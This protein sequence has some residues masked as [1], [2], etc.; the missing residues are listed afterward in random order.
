MVFADKLKDAERGAP[1]IGYCLSCR[2]E[3]G[4]NGRQDKWDRIVARRQRPSRRDE[5]QNW[6]VKNS[7][8]Q[9]KSYSHLQRRCPHLLKLTRREPQQGPGS[10]FRRRWD[11][12]MFT[13]NNNLGTRDAHLEIM[14]H[15]LR[16][17]NPIVLS[18]W[19]A[20]FSRWVGFPIG[21]KL[22]HL[23]SMHT[24]S[25]IDSGLAIELEYGSGHN[26]WLLFVLV[27]FRP[28]T[29]CHRRTSIT[30]SL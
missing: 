6:D 30:H 14:I 27:A 23:I 5:A 3:I 22:L 28:K 18:D 17:N 20:L 11:G 25:S 15:A 16:L 10:P 9:I 4:S 12:K 19:E 8:N 26:Y 29:T 24:H 1:K 21:G 13:D 7:V 2:T